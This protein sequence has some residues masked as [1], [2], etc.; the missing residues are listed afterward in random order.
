MTKIMKAVLLPEH[1]SKDVL[2]FG[3]HPIP[4]PGPGE[5]LVRV[6]AAA[7]NRLDLWVRNG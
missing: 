6:R 7:L 4:H 2:L 1:G 5:V 3:D